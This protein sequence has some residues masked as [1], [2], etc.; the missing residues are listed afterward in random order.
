MRPILLLGP[1]PHDPALRAFGDFLTS[2]GVPH[3]ACSDLRLIK[4]AYTMGRDG[5]TN[6]R[7]D[8]PGLGSFEDDEIGVLVRKAWAFAGPVGT[9]PVER[10]AAREYYSSWWSLCASLR[11]VVNRPARWAWLTERE[12][13]HRLANQVLPEFWTSSPEE[14]PGHWA[15]AGSAEIHI[16]EL[17]GFKGHVFSQRDD[18]AAWAGSMQASHVRALFAPSSRYLLQACVGGSSI[19]VRNETQIDVGTAEHRSRMRSICQQLEVVG[20]EFFGVAMVAGEDGLP[21]VT[22]IVSDPPYQWYRSRAEEIH[23]LLCARLQSMSE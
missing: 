15:R 18:L 9:G 2:R 8:V 19:A 12:A 7:L 10:F 13:W 20:L 4:F 22:R 23:E 16:E 21:Y 1:D 14:L 17:V 6:V 5:L 3:A 11:H